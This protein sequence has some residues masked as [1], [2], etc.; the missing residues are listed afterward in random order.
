M[1]STIRNITE[2]YNHRGLPPLKVHRTGAKYWRDCA[3]TPEK[4]A[5]GRL[6]YRQRGC[7]SMVPSNGCTVRLRARLRRTRRGLVNVG[8]LAEF[9]LHRVNLVGGIAVVA[10]DVAAQ[11]S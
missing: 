4:A 7:S 10:G 11:R 9:Q 5:I 8:A 1:A 3:S 2:L 6:S